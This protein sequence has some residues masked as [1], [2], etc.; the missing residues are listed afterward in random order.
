MSA[1]ALPEV[2][3]IILSW[4]RIDDTIEAIQ[5]ALEQVDVSVH[6]QIVDQGSQADG[7]KKLTAFCAQYPNVK[8][9]TNERNNGVPGGRNQASRLGSAPY[10][11]ALDN[12][13]V[14]MD[15]KQ[16]ARAV[17]LMERDQGVAA[18]AFKIVTYDEGVDDRSSWPFPH[19]IQTWSDRS[20]ETAR[21]VGAG[22]ILR[23]S[24][25]EKAGEYDDVLFFLH[26]EVDLAYRL[27]NQ[28]Q[29]I[30]YQPAICI[31][32]KV[33]AERRVSWSDGRIYYHVRNV[34]YLAFKYNFKVSGAFL[35]V[36]LAVLVG[37]KR[38]FYLGTFKGLGAGLLL[39]AKGLRQRWS[40]SRVRLT[41]A[42]KLAIRLSV[43]GG[44]LPQS[45]RALMRLKSV[46]T[47]K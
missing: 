34:V 22:H 33:S 36:F 29:R 32:H 41:D 18:M 14:F 21:F 7:L 43:P 28:G 12:D 2:D 5:S 16:A 6:V 9:V 23:R 8:L 11:I 44:E 27:M 15:D 20:F 26:E 3:I 38:G 37:V 45:R 40:D 13:A 4:D 35:N 31:R 24:T 17:E 30:I 10:I 39:S 46:L 47:N 25:F 42:T 19:P 1:D